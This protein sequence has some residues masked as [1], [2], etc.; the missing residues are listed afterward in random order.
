MTSNQVSNAVALV[1]LQALAKSVGV[2]YQAIRK[3]ERQ[4]VSAER[5]IPI[6]SATGWRI[7]PHALRPDLYPNP[8]D[9]LPSN[10]EPKQAAA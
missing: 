8:G 5:V 7:T 9:G 3:Y 6:A 10:I 2:T 4:G 1:G